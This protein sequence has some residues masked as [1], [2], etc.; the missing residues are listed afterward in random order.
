MVVFPWDL[1]LHWHQSPSHHLISSA[2]EGKE[3]S[4]LAPELAID[5]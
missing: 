2:M 1:T 5:S 4:A 3:S